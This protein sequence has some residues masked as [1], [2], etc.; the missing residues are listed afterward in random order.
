VNSIVQGVGVTVGTTGVEVGKIVL[1][2]VGVDA[3]F[4]GVG[5]AVGVLVNV[6]V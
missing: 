2:K 1:V 4:V 6:L 3:E 5:V